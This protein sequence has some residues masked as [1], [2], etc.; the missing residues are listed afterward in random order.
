VRLRVDQHGA[1]RKKNRSQGEGGREYI[2]VS[3]DISRHAT[4]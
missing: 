2:C 1:P 4:V 3:P